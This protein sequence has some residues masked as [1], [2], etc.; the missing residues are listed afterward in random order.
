MHATRLFAAAAL[1][2]GLSSPLA[3]A[4]EA[5]HAGTGE[6][7]FKRVC[8]ACHV[9]V[10]E[11]A[12]ATAPPEG[13]DPSAPRAVPR[14][15][16]R[17][18]TPESVLASLTSG[19]MQAQGSLLSEPERRAVAEF[20]SG[21][22]MGSAAQ[23]A[24]V[25]KPNLCANPRP[26]AEPARLPSWNGW[27]NDFSNA[28][29]QPKKAGGLTA[30]D[31]PKLKLKWAFGYPNV[32]TVRA[33][34]TVA[35]G[36]LFIASETG[37]VWSLNAKTGCSY[38]TW[39][40]E[41]PVAASL[42]VGPYKGADGKRILAVYIADRRANAYALDANTGK[43][44]WMR[45]VDDHK[46]AGVTGSPV[47]HDGRLFVPI[48]GIGE[49][50]TGATNN[51]AC[52]T[53]RG[54]VTALDANTG[55]QLWKTYTIGENKPRG[56]NKNG[57]QL[58]GPAGGGIWS[59]P[60]VDVKRGLV[61]AATGN[62]YAD[63]PQPGTD[64]V[65][66]MDMKT[67]AVKWIRQLQPND[68]WAMGCGPTNENNPACPEK[69][70]PDYDFS[71]SPMI[72]TAGG[73]ELLV[74]PQKSGIAWAID[75]DRQGEVV[76]QYRF[77]QGSGLGGQWGGAIDGDV[78]YFGVADILTKTP[79]GMHA[80]NTAT[81]KPLWN[82]PPQPKLCAG[83]P[84]AACSAGQGGALTAIPGAVLNGGLDGGLRAYARDT[85]EILW[86]FDTNREFETVNGLTAHGGAIDHGGPVV[87]DGMLYTNSGYGGFVAHPGNVL[88]AFGLE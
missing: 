33:Q 52:C 73:R 54:N 67:G 50:G 40:A 16:L 32:S 63:P 53:F 26:M 4:Q 42:V 75:P 9:S 36:R 64:A 69:L 13:A 62:G 72:A 46:V 15:M 10:M 80:V 51:Y 8:S 65:I 44:L 49:E 7:A 56:K 43:Q 70:G 87:V 76:W 60:T 3:L 22:A 58:F 14:E 11:N 34:P 24:Q 88:L 48:Q 39:K 35:G 28:R 23:A 61:Y 6:A 83:I 57:V 12:G 18:F 45:R 77:G 21:R 17:M 25:A 30:A 20:A 74:L 86:L 27:G 78:A 79:G 55:A 5:P 31:L 29:F 85:G 37:E 41:A 38:W 82:K 68:N 1:I 2:A 71:A 84:G 81:G 66:A 59:T 47:L 19:K